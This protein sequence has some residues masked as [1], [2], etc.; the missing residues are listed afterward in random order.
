MH[1]QTCATI[2]RLRNLQKEILRVLQSTFQLVRVRRLYDVAMVNYHAQLVS[3]LQEKSVLSYGSFL[4]S[5]P[6][7]TIAPQISLR[8][9]LF[10]GLEPLNLFSVFSFSIMTSSDEN[11]SFVLAS[12]IIFPVL[13]IIV[14]A[15]RFYT[16]STQKVSYQLDDWLILPALVGI[17]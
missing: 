5:G 3:F 9:A 12:G 2:L 7:F 15:L 6:T 17:R 11:P 8:L 16:R 4:T 1:M 10:L 13:G 14:V